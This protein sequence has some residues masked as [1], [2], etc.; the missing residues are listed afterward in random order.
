MPLNCLNQQ[1]ALRNIFVL[2]PSLATILTNTYREDSK[3][4]I[5][6]SFILSQE[7]TTQGDPLAMPMY[8]LG[9]VPLIQ[10][11]AEYKVSQM[12]Y[13]DDASAGGS[14][15]NLRSWWDCVVRLGPEFGYNP[16]A[17]KT[18]LIVKSQHL[19]KAKVLFRGTGVVIIDVGKR[20]LGSALGTDEFVTSYVQA[21]VAT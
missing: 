10:W 20:H 12:W 19:R 21:K 11:L 3:L 17:S 9:I 14:L 13:A 7:G 4:Y 15:L 5:D 2:C 8:A 18:C 6:G 1:A 16:N